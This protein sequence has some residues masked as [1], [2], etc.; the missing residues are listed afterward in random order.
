MNQQ[1]QTDH[2]LQTFALFSTHDAVLE[3]RALKV[4]KYK[5]TA[6]GY[7][8]SDSKDAFRKAVQTCAQLDPQSIYATLNPV[9]PDLLAR[10]ANRLELRA[11]ATTNDDNILRRRFI[12]IDADAVRPAGMSSSDY[13]HDA[14]LER[15]TACRDMLKNEHGIAAVLADSGNGGHVLIP[16][17][18][19]NDEESKA[20]VVRVLAT[21]SAR[22]SDDEVKIDRAVFNA[23]RI[24]KIYGTLTR[25][26][27]DVRDRPHRFSR[28][29]DV[30]SDLPPASL[31]VLWDLCPEEVESPGSSSTSTAPR[32]AKASGSG[33][34]PFDV[35]A[36]IDR[37]GIEI[38]SESNGSGDWHHWNLERCPFNPEHN[39][40][41]SIIAQNG[42]G[43]L[44]F[45]CLHN[46]CQGYRWQ[47]L[48]QKFEPEWTPFD[49]NRTPG[50]R[51]LQATR[52]TMRV[53]SAP[54]ACSEDP[55]EAKQEEYVRQRL[56]D[57][58]LATEPQN[59]IG[60]ARRL[61]RRYGQD[62]R[63]DFTSGRWFI[64][65]GKRFRPDTDGE[66]NRKCAAVAASIY[67]EASTIEAVGEEDVKAKQKAHRNFAS[68]TE[69]KAGISNMEWAARFMLA[70]EADQLDADPWILP[71]LNGLIDLRTST[72]RPHDRAALN[73]KCV[74]IV[75][76]PEARCPEWERLVNWAMCDNPE[77]VQFLQRVTGYALTGDTRERALFFLHGGGGNG[78][79][80]VVGIIQKLL[81][82]ASG[83]WQKLDAK[84]LG[85][86][87]NASG[88]A[89]NP[90]IAKLH[91]ARLV[92]VSEM[93]QGARLNE[94]LIKDLTGGQD[95]ITARFLN[96][97]PITFLPKFKIFWYGNHKP[98]IK[99]TDKG[100]W[101]RL[102][103][104]PFE[105]HI[106]KE[107]EDGELPNRLAK[108]LSGILNWSL[109]GCL[110]WQS[111]GLGTPAVVKEATEAFRNEEDTLGQFLADMCDLGPDL[112]EYPASLLAS[113]EAWC[114]TNTKMPLPGNTFGN[115]LAS[116]GYPSVPTR[117][118][119]PVV[120][121]R[122]GLRLKGSEDDVTG[123]D[124][125]T[126]CNRGFQ[127]PPPHESAG[128]NTHEKPVTTCYKY[129]SLLQ[130]ESEEKKADI[131][132]ALEQFGEM[133]R[134]AKEKKIALRSVR[135]GSGVSADLNTWVNIQV[136]K[137]REGDEE[138]QAETLEELRLCFTAWCGLMGQGE[139]QTP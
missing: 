108:E 63:Y 79:S 87:F 23:A 14:A 139:E 53:P 128:V 105:N 33:P 122:K 106:T 109:T 3:I 120:R 24:S 76:D 45:K 5:N 138:D 136:K 66:I 134:A 89:P 50:A 101:S 114:R 113:Y 51:S 93:S 27:D 75:F 130:T 77:T 60:N 94:A 110:E 55:E 44:T 123:S 83:Y 32:S 36:F 137:F 7:F 4:G 59:D 18:L 38:H 132:K 73:T 121:M 48:R 35:R 133:I 85:Q 131:P 107:Q 61:F 81:G 104:I 78:K 25:K 68:R 8:D 129:K 97:D 52:T 102:H 65:D 88:S 72:L 92:T 56:L 30:P 112:K 20:L 41:A 43:A 46:S 98:T 99:G 124:D 49:P 91:D 135:V 82:E 74:D 95:M 17:D 28:L 70:I 125:V 34:A 10:Y 15:A 39:H 6:A 80:T 62:L 29:L 96:K 12:L 42:A 16:I 103:L 9:N 71:V 84:S 13:E 37:H 21:I 119:G 54:S 1:D 64:W 40:P 26:G 2:I 115:E 118:S 57:A 11:N 100:I 127:G 69:S 126:D 111:K 47:D 22:F 90:D 31:E 86:V 67:P 116:R 19:P 117:V 58:E